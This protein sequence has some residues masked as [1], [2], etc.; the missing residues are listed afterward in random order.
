MIG[1]LVLTLTLIDRLARA[2]AEQR[3]DRLTAQ[4]A[5]AA[6]TSN[7]SDLAALR[8]QLDGAKIAVRVI[9]ER[10]RLVEESLAAQIAS[11]ATEP[12]EAVRLRQQLQQLQQDR[13]ADLVRRAEID[14]T[15]QTSHSF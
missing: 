9:Q 7:A 6:G 8:R 2:D 12:A 14:R 4:Y 15:Q 13:E 11:P 3:L 10:E 5:V 1:A